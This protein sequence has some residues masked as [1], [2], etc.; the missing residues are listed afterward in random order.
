MTPASPLH[1]LLFLF[2]QKQRNISSIV[3]KKDRQ[4]LR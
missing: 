2:L 1:S 4:T 3:I